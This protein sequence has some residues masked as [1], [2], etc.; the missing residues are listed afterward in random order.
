MPEAP[1]ACARYVSH[2]PVRWVFQLDLNPGSSS[3]LVYSVLFHETEGHVRFIHESAAWYLVVDL[4]GLVYASPFASKLHK[5]VVYPGLVVF[6]ESNIVPISFQL[7]YVHSAHIS[8]LH[9][10]MEK[11]DVFLKALSRLF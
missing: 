1:E 9:G 5:V 4:Y 8:L 7:Q 10:I 6:T 11:Q 3:N 2:L